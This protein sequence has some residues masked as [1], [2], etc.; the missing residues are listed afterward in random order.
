MHRARNTVVPDQD[1]RAAELPV[2]GDQWG[3]VV[4]PGAAFA[5]VAVAV[6]AAWPVDQPGPVTEFVGGQGC[7]GDASAGTA[8]DPHHRGS[9][10]LGPGLGLRRRHGEAG[11]VLE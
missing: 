2:C 10:T 8:A 4:A 6:I 7:D 3:A 9:A 11:F 5:S 1:D